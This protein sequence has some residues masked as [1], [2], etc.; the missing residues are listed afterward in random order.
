MED[1]AIQNTTNI[2]GF[3]LA[4]LMVVSAI[5]VSSTRQN[6]AK[7]LLVTAA[8]VPLGQEV[9]VFG[10]HFTF[11]RILILIALYVAYLRVMK[12]P[13]SI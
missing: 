9:V 2:N 5:V 13:D 3:A 8:F 11:L 4:F 1:Y 12:S 6:A 10:L 7:T